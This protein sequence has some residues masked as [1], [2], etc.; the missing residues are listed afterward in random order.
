VKTIAVLNGPNLDRL[1]RREP[2]IYGR[3]TLADLERKLRAEA[4]DLGVAIDF[5]QSNHEG[6]LIDRI[7][8]M[9]DAGVAGLILN[10]A[11]LTHTS[12]ALRDAIKGSGLPTVEVHIS[13]IHAREEF[14]AHSMTAPV[15]VGVVTGL[16][17]AGY[18]FALKFLADRI[19]A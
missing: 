6:A 13:N 2:E 16:G 14:R 11:G 4:A 7:S 8:A 12:V 9:P 1:G 15:C 18:S 19:R 5:F 3:D 10:A 17:L